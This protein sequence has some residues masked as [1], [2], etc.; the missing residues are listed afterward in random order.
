[1]STFTRFVSRRTAA[2]AGTVTIVVTTIVITTVAA[3]SASAFREPLDE[4]PCFI[5]QPRWNTAIDGPPPGCTSHPRQEPP[6]SYGA[7]SA[8]RPGVDAMP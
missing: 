2:C 3:P 1:M 5:V 7:W 4:R 6:A 8:P